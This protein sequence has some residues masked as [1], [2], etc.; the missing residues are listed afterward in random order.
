MR[1]P[2]LH[3]EPG[4]SP[5]NPHAICTICPARLQ[6]PDR[7][8]R[9]LGNRAGTTVPRPQFS[10]TTGKGS[11]MTATAQAITTPDYAAIKA[12]QNAAWAS[13]DY[14]RIGTTLQIVGE[15]L[16]EAMDLTPGSSVLDVA[17]GNGNATLAFA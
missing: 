8:R 5:K 15:T 1:L 2:R 4:G 12:K 10:Q 11:I 7:A 6:A 14:A 17:A 13:G 9:D 3:R 16:A